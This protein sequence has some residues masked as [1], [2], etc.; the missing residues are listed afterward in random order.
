MIIY[1][2]RNSVSKKKKEGFKAL[3]VPEGVAH[4]LLSGHAVLDY[5]KWIETGEVLFKKL[6]VEQELRVLY[7]P[8]TD[9]IFAVNNDGTINQQIEIVKKEN[10]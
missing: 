2:S 8:M 9:K 4:V 7:D 3:D 10:K 5:D 6:V 1:V